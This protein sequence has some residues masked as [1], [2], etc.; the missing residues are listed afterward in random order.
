MKILIFSL[1]FEICSLV[2][3]HNGKQSVD[4][5]PPYQS[6]LARSLHYVTGRA[7]H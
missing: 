7:S 2:G 3:Y 5:M 1:F 4:R 6:Y